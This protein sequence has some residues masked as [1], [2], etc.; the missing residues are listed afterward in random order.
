MT[1]NL[2][3][4]NKT[5]AKRSYK[6]EENNIHIIDCDSKEELWKLYQNGFPVLTTPYTLSS[7]KS[8]PHFY[9]RCNNLY[10]RILGSDFKPKREIDL[11]YWY[12]YE[13]MTRSIRGTA[14]IPLIPQKD[15]G[16][17]L[18]MSQ[19]LCKES[20]CPFESTNK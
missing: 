13:K 16:N 19:I 3:P 20:E 9:I 17:Y 11:L 6:K 2:K 18:N 15:L 5:L 1:A 14:E 7:T 12:A 8:L 4:K 10:D